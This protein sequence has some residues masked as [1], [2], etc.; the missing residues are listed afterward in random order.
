M[1]HRDEKIVLN[2]LKAH[3]SHR[4]LMQGLIPLF[5]TSEQSSAEV[6]ERYVETAGGV[7]IKAK[8]FNYLL[9]W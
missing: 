1:S 6:K 4:Q 3:K 9:A 7:A 2:P 8:C 5:P